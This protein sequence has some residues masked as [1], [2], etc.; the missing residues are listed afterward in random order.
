[1]NALE[2]KNNI[3]IEISNYD[4]ACLNL[5]YFD[6]DK[7]AYHNDA[8]GHDSGDDV[9]NKILEVLLKFSANNAVCGRVGGDEFLVYSISS[10]PEHNQMGRFLQ[11]SIH[12]LKL[13]FV[14]EG[15]Q[16]D[17]VILPEFIT[18]S[19]VALS[20]PFNNIEKIENNKINLKISEDVIDVLIKYVEYSMYTLKLIESGDFMA[21]DWGDKHS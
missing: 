21:I 20:F 7:F 12:D 2:I 16:N 11:K 14:G 4:I 6:I 10:K 3:A 5:I 9:L 1:M 13:P 18:C 8:L 15:Y 19:A 17:K